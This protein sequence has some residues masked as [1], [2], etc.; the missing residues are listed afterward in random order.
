VT[1]SVAERLGRAAVVTA[2]VQAAN[3]WS[4]GSGS[5]GQRWHRVAE[6]HGAVALAHLASS[7]RVLPLV[8]FVDGLTGPLA[9]LLPEG[10]RQDCDEAPLVEGDELSGPAFD[11]LRENLAPSVTATQVADWDW[12]MLSAEKIQGWLYGQLLATGSQEGYEAARLTVIRYAAGPLVDINDRVKQVGLPRDGL[13]EPIP[14]W[15]WATRNGERYWFACPICRW[16]MRF[17]LGRVACCYLPHASA[18]GTPL[19]KWGATGPPELGAWRRDRL[20]AAGIPHDVEVAANLVEEHVSLVRPVW[21]YSTVPGV[22]EWYLARKCNDMAGVTATLWPHTD[23]YD[24]LVEIEGRKRR[25]RV[26]VKDYTDPGR[27]VGVLAR[28]EALR[29]GDM[30]IVV[31]AHRADQVGL[32]NER[33]QDAFGQPRRRFA[34]TSA[35][36]LRQVRTAARLEGR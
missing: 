7:G 21:R 14:G 28:N 19:V 35:Q 24:L 13:Y 36:F 30:L 5:A 33:L 25:W 20:S 6:L 17:Q 29:A 15:A 34:A 4:S 22:E 26:D 32:L 27:L 10:L 3:V 8:E 16:P 11:L 12:E 1:G 9:A 31:P 23:A 2:C 18:I